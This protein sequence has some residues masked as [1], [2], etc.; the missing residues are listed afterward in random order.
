MQMRRILPILLVLCLCLLCAPVLADGDA[1]A[2]AS[3]RFV[4][5]ED[6]QARTEY[7]SDGDPATRLS[8]KKGEE[9]RVELDGASARL[10]AE[11]YVPCAFAVELLDADGTVLRAETVERSGYF[12]SID[13]TNAA[14]CVFRSLSNHAAFCSVSVYGACF[15]PPFNADLTATDILVILERPED[16]LFELGGFLA[17]Y[18]GECGVSVRPLFLTG[19]G[20]PALMHQLFRGME[21]MGGSAYPIFADYALPASGNQ[22]RLERAFGGSARLQAYLASII[23]SYAPRVVI[24]C[25]DEPGNAL[26]SV[27]FSNVCGALELA[28]DPAFSPETAPHAVLK[29]YALDQAGT[30]VVDLSEPLLRYGGASALERSQLAYRRCTAQLVY[31]HALPASLRL[32]L[33]ASAVGDD[34]ARNDV[35]EHIETGLLTAYTKP[36]PTPAP[37]A[38]PTPAPTPSPSL[39]PVDA[40]PAV[41]SGRSGAVW[42]PIIAGALFGVAGAGVLVKKQMLRMLPLALAPL[43]AGIAVGL[44]LPGRVSSAPAECAPAATQKPPFSASPR[45]TLPPPA[46]TPAPDAP[47]SSAHADRFAAYGAEETIL[48]DF[49]NGVW[50]YRGESLGVFIARKTI[51]IGGKPVVSYVA[52]IYMRDFSSYRSGIRDVCMPHKYARHERAVLAITGDNLVRAEKEKK[53]CLI[54][55]GKLYCDYNAA[56]TLVIHDDMTLSVLSPDEF[57]ADELIDAGVRHTYSFGPILVRDGKI[58]ELCGKHRVAHPN[59]RCGIGMVEP[60]HWIAIVTDGRQPGYSHSIRLEDFAQMFL[61]LGCGTA[62][63]LDGGSSAAMVFMGEVLNCHQGSGTADPMRSWADALMWGWSDQLPPVEQPTE[64]RGYHY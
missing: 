26:R 32:T 21:D 44:L 29:H 36:S 22:A 18:A 37:T 14:A 42:P 3:V 59:P 35:L 12:Y 1:A 39:T 30:T 40:A 47:V 58:N 2:S 8:L 43:A 57:A 19:C 17:R 27:I 46:E 60:G 31:R 4:A 54:R 7:L 61:S 15:E 20:D 5:P 6:K 10:V 49:E 45:P 56:D 52:D 23:R 9:L 34:L 13:V 51:E 63:N 55:N 62:Y 64:H 50:Q 41:A 48:S 33:T 24:S 38:A 16:M 53:G 11:L 25:A 28:A